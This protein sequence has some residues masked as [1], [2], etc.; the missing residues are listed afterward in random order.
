MIIGISTNSS[1]VE[2]QLGKIIQAV[3]YENN[4]HP[5]NFKGDILSIMNIL[6]TKLDLEYRSTFKIV[7][8]ADIL[9]SIVAIMLDEPDFVNK[10]E[11]NDNNY[12]D[13]ELG[14]EWDK[15]KVYY[16]RGIPNF[17]Y[18]NTLK[19]AEEWCNIN[20]S[21]VTLN[22]QPIEKIIMTKRKLL[23]IQGTDCGRNIIHPNCWINATMVNYKAIKDGA[24]GNRQ[25]DDLDDCPIN[26]PN[27]IIT[28][29][30][31]PNEAKAIEDRG[32]FIIRC[33]RQMY[34]YFDSIL[35]LQEV[36]DNIFKDTGEYPTKEYLN[37]YSTIDTNQHK[38]ET[39][40]DNHKFTY[41]VDNNGTIEELIKQVKDIL[42]K[43]KII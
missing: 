39:S 3:I 20:D 32:G 5:T 21:I 30:G 33:N 38:S 26:F 27:W 1:Q 22:R 31:F 36:K 28:D 2:I 29:V 24:T 12:R 42:I 35:S 17:K 8:F 16:C 10:W 6:N 18:F 9:K 41:N 15:Y 23:Q 40:L 11:A 25:P 19:E 34:R 37:N 13:K 7:K 4:T 43:E 14:K